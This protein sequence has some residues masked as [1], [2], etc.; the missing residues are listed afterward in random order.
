MMYVL[1]T[2]MLNKGFVMPSQ[3]F[4]K[5]P[6]EITAEQYFPGEKV[7]GVID[8]TDKFGPYGRVLTQH[9]PVKVTPGQWVITG[10]DGERYPIT[11]ELLKKT[12]DEVKE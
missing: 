1:V 12:Y 8:M 4:R 11:D 5:K 6:L 7:K 2:I 3:R 9:G 10:V